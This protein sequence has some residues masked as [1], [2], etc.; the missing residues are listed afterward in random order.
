[1]KHDSSHTSVNDP[2][3]HRDS[4]HAQACYPN[5]TE[6]NKLIHAPPIGCA[7]LS[8]KRPAKGASGRTISTVYQHLK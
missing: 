5:A 4:H 8:Q 2:A 1:M 6:V 3:T 7:Q